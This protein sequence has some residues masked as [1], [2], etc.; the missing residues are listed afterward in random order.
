MKGKCMFGKY[1]LLIVIG[2]GGDRLCPAR[3]GRTGMCATRRP[4]HGLDLSA[5]L[6]A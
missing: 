4:G 6:R 5:G 3:L 1:V 2:V